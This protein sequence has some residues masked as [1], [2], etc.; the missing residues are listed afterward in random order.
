MSAAGAYG[1]AIA[2][3]PGWTPAYSGL[4]TALV[5]QG[6]NES[7]REI[8]RL[9]IQ[10]APG[11]TAALLASARLEET[12]QNSA[13][14]ARLCSQVSAIEPANAEAAECIRRNQPGGSVP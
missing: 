1:R 8:L 10:R 7:A 5:G 9:A 14:A 4:A 11:D 6:R 12:L 3:R 13:E 2:L